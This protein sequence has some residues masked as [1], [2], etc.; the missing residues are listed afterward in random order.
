[1]WSTR[2]RWNMPRELDA[3]SG[4]RPAGTGQHVVS[5]CTVAGIAGKIG[6]VAACACDPP[7]NSHSPCVRGGNDLPRQ[8]VKKALPVAFHSSWAGPCRTIAAAT[9]PGLLGRGLFASEGPVL[10][11]DLVER[12]GRTHPAEPA[13]P[14]VPLAPSTVPLRLLGHRA[15]PSLCVRDHAF[16]ASAEGHEVTRINGRLV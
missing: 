11:H 3:L 4:P 7:Q 14:P 6:G 5:R 16:V 10:P 9:R 12:V 8:D 1:M 13:I 15:P 2:T